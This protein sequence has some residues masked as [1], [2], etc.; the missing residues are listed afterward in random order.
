MT[1]TLTPLA[2]ALS[3]AALFSGGALLTACPEEGGGGG[4]GDNGA[5]GDKGD[6]GDPGPAGPPGADG[7]PGA[8][9]EDGQDGGGDVDGNGERQIIK[10][11]G[12]DDNGVD[13]DT[14]ILVDF[15][16]TASDALLTG[17]SIT[18]SF[19]RRAAPE[20]VAGVVANGCD[21]LGDPIDLTCFRI[22]NGLRELDL[23]NDD[24]ADGLL[25]VGAAFHLRFD[26]E[27]S[28]TTRDDLDDWIHDVIGIDAAFIVTESA[29]GSEYELRYQLT[30]ELPIASFNQ[31]GVNVGTSILLPPFTVTDINGDGNALVEV[32]LNDGAVL[33]AQK[34]PAAVL[35][36]PVANI[37]N[38]AIREDGKFEPGDVFSLAFDVA[39][40]PESTEQA[41]EVRLE[42]GPFDDVDV[43]AGGGGLFIVSVL[44]AATVDLTASA[45]AFELVL[46]P[47][48]VSSAIGVT[49]STQQ[50]RFL[51]TDITVPALNVIN[52]ANADTLLVTLQT[53]VPPRLNNAQQDNNFL[54]G[55]DQLTFLF[56]E[57]M[58]VAT[59]QADIA[60]LLNL[61]PA[62]NAANVISAAA[63]DVVNILGGFQFRYTLK[64][65]EGIVV[66]AIF[67]LG[68]L[69]SATVTD[70]DNAVDLGIPLAANQTPKATRA[71]FIVQATLTQVI[72]Q[73]VNGDTLDVVL[74]GGTPREDNI[75]EAGDTLLFQFTKR[76]DPITTRDE[77]AERIVNGALTGGT[78]TGTFD[79]ATVTA[80]ILVQ[81]ADGLVGNRFS[82]TLENDQE[83]QIT[84]NDMLFGALAT[85]VLD[86]NG[87]SLTA[88]QNPLVS[89]ENFDPDLAPTLA[90]VVGTRNVNT[91]CGD[92]LLVEDDTLAFTFSEALD[93]DSV[94]DAEA[95]VI[96][97]VNGVAN[98][99][100][101]AAGDVAV[102]GTNVFVVTLPAGASLATNN[103][104]NFTLAIAG[105]EDANGVD[106]VALTAAL[107]PTDKLAASLAIVR[108][109]VVNDGR[110]V[111]GDRLAITWS[112]Q[113]DEFETLS[114]VQQAVD[115]TM[116]DGTA[117][118][119]TAN[120]VTFVVEILPGRV[121]DLPAQRILAIA[122][123]AT[124]LD[125]NGENDDGDEDGD[126]R[127]SVAGP[128]NLAFD[129]LP[130]A[131]VTL[132]YVAGTAD[133]FT[134]VFQAAA[135]LETG[136][137]FLSSVSPGI[138]R[139]EIELPVVFTDFDVE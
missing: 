23:E 26:R 85:T 43:S 30:E 64:A 27:M 124:D 58:Q 13:A 111:A 77:L 25:D 123:V 19:S 44:G 21:S 35:F 9:G 20:L 69:D 3:L 117:R 127:V 89:D 110:L 130:I 120:N 63:G 52:V 88:N 115:E 48:D 5:K 68:A 119:T 67:T 28:L 109:F 106:A 56:S 100:D 38:A 34:E 99:T 31:A 116:A 1:L 32:V 10:L 136:T 126:G 133:G 96:T 80:R 118:T 36:D 82:Y 71:V 138:T 24:D 11:T 14:R 40:D 15:A 87:L 97:A 61:L 75:I 62:Q 73:A 53:A 76:M 132:D 2:K 33:A 17:E 83:F 72:D 108:N 139:G 112:C 22:V 135:A 66:D 131:D 79:V 18:V 70:L 60:R 113:M 104:I 55:G 16:G 4:N 46:Q 95:A 65:G 74:G 90:T 91:E 101:V 47:H 84:A 50:L 59:V 29:P 49:N 54:V 12:L 134:G 45:G 92:S 125:I 7:A 41:L 98:G 121:F 81:S 105:I 103:A 8:D 114:S 39:M 37:I 128:F 86:D 102:I 57:Q 122:N 93:P 51:I 6:P 107:A 42:E 94:D 129:D 137:W 78:R